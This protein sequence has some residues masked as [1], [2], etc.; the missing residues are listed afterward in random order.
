MSVVILAPRVAGL[1][2]PVN[3]CSWLLAMLAFVGVRF[4]DEMFL[5]VCRLLYDQITES[6]RI[7]RK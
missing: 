5:F 2:C 4:P 1:F 6:N 7:L 3:P